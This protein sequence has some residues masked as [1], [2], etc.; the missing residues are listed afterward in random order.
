[1][2]KIRKGRVTLKGVLA[3]TSVRPRQ[4]DTATDRR[5]TMDNRTKDEQT[6]ERTD[7]CASL[8]SFSL[9]STSSF[10]PVIKTHL[11]TLQYLHSQGHRSHIRDSLTDRL[12]ARGSMFEI[13][14][15]L[16]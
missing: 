9:T 13:N 3:T 16:K 1:M 12:F 8:G 2:A 4:A 14:K 5:W 15:G 6:D 10:V 7:T 11:L